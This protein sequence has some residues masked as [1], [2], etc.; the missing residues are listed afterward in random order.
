MDRRPRSAE[1]YVSE[2]VREHR[3][4]ETLQAALDNEECKGAFI[5]LQ[6]SLARARIVSGHSWREVLALY[7]RFAAS[8]PRQIDPFWREVLEKLRL[9]RAAEAIRPG[10]RYMERARTATG[11][12]VEKLI[13]ELKWAR[14]SML[15]TGLSFLDGMPVTDKVNSPPQ[16]DRR[17]R[18]PDNTFG[19]ALAALE[20]YLNRL[21]PSAGRP[22]L[23]HTQ[24]IATPLLRQLAAFIR[25]E[26]G[27]PHWSETAA[28]LRRATGDAGWTAD[29][30]KMRA[31]PKRKKS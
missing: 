23:R 18:T 10:P 25:E 29:R 21:R 14:G 11:K 4:R 15:R 20:S 31:E 26:T 16:T 13:R 19:P 22:V 5:R 2:V 27:K 30:L 9:I 3:D 17:S 8:D 28:L 6:R 7:V 12:R 24:H 1:P